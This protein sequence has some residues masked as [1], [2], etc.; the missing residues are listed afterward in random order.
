MGYGI[1]SH[2]EQMSLNDDI[3]G[4]NTVEWHALLNVGLNNLLFGVIILY[5]SCIV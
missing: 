2:N 5:L 3:C 1:L 4:S